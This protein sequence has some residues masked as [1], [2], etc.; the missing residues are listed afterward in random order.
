MQVGKGGE[1]RQPG[2][3]GVEGMEFFQLYVITQKAIFV[4]MN[5][6]LIYL[7]LIGYLSMVSYMVFFAPGRT[8]LA[9]EKRRDLINLVPLKQKI[10]VYSNINRLNKTAKFNYA[11][12]LVG[13]VLLFFPFPFM[14]R[15]LGISIFKTMA[16]AILI[17]VLIEYVQFQFRVGVADIDDVL[18]NSLGALLG[19]VIFWLVAPS[20]KQHPIR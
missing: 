10:H 11:F 8:M 12:N 14:L 3:C 15:G 13:N 19:L 20:S 1:G 18:L 16:A 5:R 2:S 4:Q 9:T 7:L 17:S 6:V